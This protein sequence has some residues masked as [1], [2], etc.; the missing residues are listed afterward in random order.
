[1]DDRQSAVP[2]FLVV[3]MTNTLPRKSLGV[4]RKGTLSANFAYAVCMVS[5]GLISSLIGMSLF[6]QAPA[7]VAFD[8]RLPVHTI[9]REDIFAGYAGDMDRLVRGE[10][11]LEALL[12]ERPDAKA[13]LTA[14]KGSIA[15]T[16]ATLAHEAARTAEF[17]LQYRKALDLYAEAQRLAPKDVGVLAVTGGSYA[18]FGD[19]LPARYRSEAWAAAYKAYSGIWQAQ[20][21]IVDHLPLH[22]KGELLAGMAQSAQRTGHAVEF[23]EFLERI[24]KTMPGT[25]YASVAQK[26]TENPSVVS[27]TKVTCMTCHEAGK[28]AARTAALAK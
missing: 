16:R 25:P 14:W 18:V 9:L 8:S 15:L 21:G 26:W 12:V 7:T 5:K 10:R 2:S 1:M 19:R 13:S 23:A 4:N 22:V 27:T 28:L 17:D 24:V 3:S 11:N 6:A 20:S